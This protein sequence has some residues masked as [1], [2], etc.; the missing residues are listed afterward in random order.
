MKN[1]RKILKRGLIVAM[2]LITVM[3]ALLAMPLC[4]SAATNRAGSY[5][6]S[7]SYNIGDGSKSGYLSNF[8]ITIGSQYFYDDSASV[9]QTKYNYHTFDWTY[10]KFYIYADDIDSHTSF[11]LYRNGSLY[12]SE[13]L[14]GDSSGYLY[15]GSLS[16]GDYVLTYEGKYWSGAFTKKTYNFTY[17]FT[18]DTTAPSV[19]LT[20]GGSYISSGSYTNKA[21]K[22]SASDSYSTE[23]IYYKSPNASS[24]SYVTATSKS[25]TASSSNNGRWYF[26]ASDGYQSSSTYSVYLDTVSPTGTIK[27]SSGSTLSSGSYT[28]SPVKYSAT[29]TGGVSY[30]QVITPSS[31]SWANYSAGTALSSSQGWYYFR[32]VDKASNT[33]STS[34]VYY[35]ATKPYGTLYG[36]TTSRSSG[37]SVN[38]SYIKYQAYDSHSGVSSI[39]V[40]KP[41]SSSYTSYTSG[42]QLTDAGTY[43]FYCIDRS[44]NYSDTVSITIDRTIPTAQLYVDGEAVGNGTYTNGDYISF[45]S[46]GSCFVKLPDSDSFIQYVSGTEF[47]KSGKYVFY[48]KDEAG[49]STGEYT[50]VIDRTVKSVILGNVSDGKTDGDV[51]V[52]WTDGDGNIYAP[53]SSVTVNG[54]PVDNGDIIHTIATGE[55]TVSVTDAAGNTWQTCFTSSK[56]NILTDTLQKEY[57]ETADGE[58]NIFSFESYDNA[59]AFAAEREYGYVT[60]KTWSS[61]IWDTGVPMDAKDSVNAANGEYF[62]YKK[63]G[64][65]DELVAYFTAERLNEVIAEYADASIKSYYYWQKEPA[66]AAEGETLYL[67]SAE[68]A[69]VANNI[70]LGE[71]I[72]VLLDGEA[73]SEKVITAEGNHTITVLDSFGNT[74]DYA[75]T[76]VRST[77]KVHYSIGDGTLNEVA[78][79]RTYYFKDDVTVSIT[80]GMDEYAMFRVLDKQGNIISIKSLGE[81][82]TLTDSGEYTV[83]AVNHAGDSQGF[84]ML[85]SRSSPTVDMRADAEEKQL[86]ITVTPSEDREAHIQSL[87][88]FKSTDG[89]STWQT[90]TE[91]D[92]GTQILTDRYKYEFRTSGLYKVVLTDEFRTGIDAVTATLDYVQPA[93]QGMLDGVENGGYTNSRVKFIWNDEAIVTVTKDG[94]T[95]DYR[96]GDILNEDGAYVIVFENYDGQRYEYSFVIDSVKPEISVQGVRGEEP[97]TSPVTVNF[98]ATEHTAVIFRNGK[99]ASYVSG[100]QISEHGRYTVLVSDKAGN[101][102]EVVFVID[103]K[104]DYTANVHNA[105]VSTSVTI[106]P[107]ED[108]TLVLTKNGESVEYKYGTEITEAGE[109]TVTMSDKYGNSEELRFTVVNATVG[110]LVYNF[111]A[112]EGFERVLVGGEEKRLN[113]G[114]LELFEDG[115]YEVEVIANGISYG[116]TVTVD[117]VAPTLTL[118]GVDNGGTT[119]GNVIIT[120]ISPD[121]S[122]K[123][124]LDG[125]PIEYELGEKL[126]DVGVYKI[127]LEDTAGNV[128]EYSFEILWKMPSAAIVLIVV[129]VLGIVGAV[130]W[131]LI[132]NKRKEKYY[133]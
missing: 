74:C 116:F 14:S 98:D 132:S 130:V 8:R 69:I 3:S 60:V 118:E 30:C 48:A 12:V 54:V 89:G 77:P 65:P 59:F 100:T 111:D 68:T 80:D 117:A 35:D 5:T 128:S 131:I 44:G 37:S 62:I 46:D 29:D 13:S 123:V 26:Y 101:V 67:D 25:V 71:N 34:S 78:F 82:F 42:T 91:D 10:F 115:N 21:I 110:K 4:T 114:T 56:K 87:E 1:K 73:F 126:K 104:V 7:G 96:S 27:N 105:S 125:K 36:G 76:V 32:A 41:N 133:S 53:I 93:P 63:S 11:K 66:A 90:L 127:V 92:Y 102:S 84:K 52:G 81:S 43:Y 72:G 57:F 85:I 23:K 79:D 18:V 99:K 47:N 119:K 64:S 124:Y 22:F 24:Y 39:Y 94:E 58:D 75:V 33:S 121:A 83:I 109:Y 38:S 70:V 106:T 95:I 16:D 61:S 122:M 6:I 112:V 97:S 108:V 9:A 20:A 51:T 2:A 50:I 107:E 19:S 88:I 31:S 129:G 55:Y 40:R 113:Y 120:D 45:V 28:N 17:N 49:N 103:T 86:I 15:Q